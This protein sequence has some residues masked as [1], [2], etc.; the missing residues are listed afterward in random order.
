MRAVEVAAE[1]RSKGFEEGVPR[2]ALACRTHVEPRPA[3]IFV[4]ITLGMRATIS[5][6]KLRGA[7]G[8]TYDEA[9]FRLKPRYRSSGNDPVQVAKA[10]L[11][12][13]QRGPCG[14]ER[15][16]RKANERLGNS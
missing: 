16:L 5:F 1:W 4:A 8:T 10:C 14:D 3:S 2:L 15:A 12:I 13:F 7:S 11:G 6:Q 9:D